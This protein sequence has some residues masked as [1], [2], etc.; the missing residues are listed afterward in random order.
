MNNKNYAQADNFLLFSSI[1]EKSLHLSV[2]QKKRTRNAKITK[3]DLFCAQTPG[4]T[5]ELILD[6]NSDRVAHAR[7]KT[8]LSR[9][10]K[11]DL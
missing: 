8:G 2:N 7:R 11:S 9:I 1:T 5:M 3:V 6:G 10:K 4:I